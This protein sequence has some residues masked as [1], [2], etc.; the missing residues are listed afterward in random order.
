MIS[1]RLVASI[2]AASNDDDID[3]RIM[4]EMTARTPPLSPPAAKKIRPA[5][6]VLQEAQVFPVICAVTNDLSEPAVMA[7]RLARFPVLKPTPF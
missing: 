6:G 1:S 7:H 2:L 4:P 3:N 5:V